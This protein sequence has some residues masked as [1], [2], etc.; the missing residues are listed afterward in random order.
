MRNLYRKINKYV[1]M[2][3]IVIFGISLISAFVY[4]LCAA[5]EKFADLINL[6]CAPIRLTISSI[7][8]IFSFSLFEIFLISTPV[9]FVVLVFFAVKAVKKS[10]Q[11]T[12]KYLCIIISI[13]LCYFISFVW[14]FA[15]G[16]HTTPVSQRL[17]IDTDNITTNDMADALEYL[18]YELNELKKGVKYDENGASIMEYSYAEMSEKISQAYKEMAKDTNSVRTFNSRVKPIILSEPMA[19]THISGVYI[20]IT[21]EANINTAYSD[22]IIASTAAHEMAHQRGIAR[23]DEA[24]FVGFLSLSYSNDTYLKYSGY[25][26]A[27]YYLLSDLNK[28]SPKTAKEIYAKLDQEIKNDYNAYVKSFQK[29][30]N[31]TASKVTEAVNNSYLQVNGDK[32]GTE[33]YNLVSKLVCAYLKK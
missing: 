16:Y 33:S 10:N 26:N 20:S 3:A 19:Y 15:S 5:F 17:E 8:S 11:A 9:L 24:S 29:Y 18:T 32:N 28:S 23:E 1:P 14:T 4:L 2:A 27:Y 7:T 13:P 22:Y 21:G 31:S 12:I 30:N 6:I 25:L